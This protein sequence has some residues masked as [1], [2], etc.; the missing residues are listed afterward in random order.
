MYTPIKCN[1]WNPNICRI[2]AFSEIGLPYFSLQRYDNYTV[3]QLPFRTN[4]V[5]CAQTYFRTATLSKIRMQ[6][7]RELPMWQYINILAGERIW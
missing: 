5:L 3:K 4:I 6:S 1:T 2:K 7:S